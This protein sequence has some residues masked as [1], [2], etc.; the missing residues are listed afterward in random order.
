MTETINRV[1]RAKATEWGWRLLLMVLTTIIGIMVA[2]GNAIQ[3]AKDES[4]NR[5]IS[6]VEAAISDLPDIREQVAILNQN[7]E[8]GRA[9]RI[10]FQERADEK[11]DALRADISTLTTAVAVLSATI[12]Q[13]VRGTPGPPPTSLMAP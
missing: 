4:A 2:Q 7:A 10:A 11:L 9:D 8:R 12:N 5:R 1:L 3:A 6:G 13:M